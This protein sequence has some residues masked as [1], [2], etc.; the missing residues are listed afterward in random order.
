M[1]SVGIALTNVVLQFGSI[2]AGAGFSVAEQNKIDELQD[3]SDKLKDAVR[4]SSNLYDHVYYEVAVSLS[5]AKKSLEKLPSDLLKTLQEQI[6]S[7]ISVGDAERAMNT[8]A[9]V[10]GYTGGGIGLLGG[11]LTLVRWLRNRKASKGEPE[12]ETQPDPFEDVPLEGGEVPAVPEAESS[13]PKSPR[14]TKVINGINVAGVVFGVAGLATTIGLGVWTLDK[15]NKAISDVER[16][17]RQVDAFEKA[18]KRALDPIVESAGLPEKSYGE[19]VTMAHTWRKLSENFDSYEKAMYYAIRGAFMN[20]P[21]PKIKEMVIKESDKGKP[22]PEDGYALTKILAADIKEQFHD[23]KTDREVV[24]F[25]ATMNPKVGLR[26][27][28]DEFFISSLR[29]FL[30]VPQPI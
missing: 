18:M 6:T 21:R 17:Q 1:V 11:L 29:W 3:K 14:L 19:L 23:N 13:F 7:D 24:A 5:R 9:K 27:V 8:L 15:L 30:S 22:F 2:G 25:F 20:L 10:L 12:P 16:K 28:F 26:F 4:T